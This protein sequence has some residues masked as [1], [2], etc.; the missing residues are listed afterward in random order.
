MVKGL[1][2]PDIQGELLA[3][4]EQMD[5][6][7]TVAFVEIREVDKKGEP[8]ARPPLPVH[9]ANM[10]NLYQE[11]EPESEPGPELEPGPEPEPEP[12]HVMNNTERATNSP[13]SQYLDPGGEFDEL[14]YTDDE[15]VETNSVAVMHSTERTTK[16]HPCQ[17]RV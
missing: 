13:L 9:Y 3:Q 8:T 11:H 16:S 2:D 10:W 14:W 7:T 5:L 15:S 12:D 4:L 1:V 17:Y 6:E